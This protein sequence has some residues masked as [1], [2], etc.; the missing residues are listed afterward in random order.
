VSANASER[1]RKRYQFR[2]SMVS[3]DLC[4]ALATGDFT[5]SEMRLLFFLL[6]RIELGSC[7]VL[8]YTNVEAAALLSASE[9]TTSRALTALEQRQ[10]V[11]RHRRHGRVDLVLNPRLAARANQ[12]Q[13]TEL[14]TT[15]KMPW[16]AI[17]KLHPSSR[18]SQTL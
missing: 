1:A 10:I 8:G 12:A 9:S 17:R 16:Q 13:R 18:R 5:A 11:Q 7:E 14:L 6:A 3:H 2:F 15:H 4:L